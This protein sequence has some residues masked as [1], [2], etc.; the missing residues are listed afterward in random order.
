MKIRVAKS[1]TLS[2]REISYSI[3]QETAQMQVC[4]AVVIGAGEE[5]RHRNDILRIV[6]VDGAQ[7]AEFAFAGGVIGDDLGSLN[8][9]ALAVGFLADEIN[10]GCL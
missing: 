5:R 6:I 2:L 4:D 1:K 8:V 10:L 7:V 3:G 9:D